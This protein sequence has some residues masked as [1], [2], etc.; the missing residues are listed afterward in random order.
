LLTAIGIGFFGKPMFKSPVF[1]ANLVPF[2]VLGA[3]VGVA[4]NRGAWASGLVI[5]LGAGLAG[6]TLP[7]SARLTPPENFGP[8][9]AY[10]AAEVHEGDVVVVPRNSV[11]WGV[12]RYAASPQWGAPLG[13]SP[14]S[15]PQWTR[16]K[17]MLGP[18]LWQTLGLNAEGNFFDW[19]GVRYI[20]GSEIQ[21]P[22]MGRIWIV[23]RARYLEHIR[24]NQPV[25]EQSV[26]WFGDELSV[27]LV[28]VQAS[29]V[30]ELGPPAPQPP[31]PH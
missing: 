3:A 14:P 4:R 15:N 20:Y 27:S 30:L 25:R 19:Q 1:T 12:M 16:L 7:W 17:R 8:A 28:S 6:A 11:Y 10:L 22:K 26:R 24:F 31:T 18:G 21:V 13:I 29:G 23:H 2:I 9:G 5:L